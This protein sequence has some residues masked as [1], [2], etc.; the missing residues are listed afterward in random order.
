MANIEA[1]DP[2]ERMSWDSPDDVTLIPKDLRVDVFNNSYQGWPSA[3][4][5]H[6]AVRIT[7]V[8]SGFVSICSDY[9]VQIKNRDKAL[10]DLRRI[11]FDAEMSSRK[12]EDQ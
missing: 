9:E 7:H 10:D 8:P 2:D 11:I 5:I 12:P 6:P 3:G 1:F 4:N